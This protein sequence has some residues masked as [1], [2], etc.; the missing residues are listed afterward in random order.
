MAA[1][2]S[3]T[4]RRQSRWQRA[5]G[6]ALSALGSLLFL[7]ITVSAQ[8]GA[9]P[10]AAAGPHP[11]I[12]NREAIAEG[13]K[14]YNE[15]C[16][17]CHGKDGTGGEL[18]PPVA[19][20]NRRY[21]RRTDDEIFDAIKNG[22][23]GT[24]MPPYTGQFTDD[25][26]W[27]VTAY[28]RGLRGT[29]IDTPVAGDVAGGEAI[30][31]GKGGCGS[32]H[33]VKAKGSILGPD[34][35][36]LAGTRKVQNIVDALTKQNHKIAADGGTH[37]TTLLPMTTYQPVRITTAD[38]KVI[39]GILKNEDSFSLQVLGRDDLNLYRFKRSNVKVFYDPQSI[40]PHDWDKRL[41]P[42]EFQNLLAF[43]TRLYVPPPPAPPARGGG[44][45][46]G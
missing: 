34:L 2:T 7:S 8:R 28:I 26:I 9:G 19:A 45:A 17:A 15:T 20:Q 32:C 21:L 14:L 4:A 23:T 16:T 46:V 42:A 22:I 1:H 24:Q 27:R 35:S 41:T 31:W 37:D 39:S 44:G 40:M 12:G 29:A 10:G 36:N 18:G 38:G 25:Q 30:F 6:I 33:M 43:L 13:E 5:N 11:A 3:P